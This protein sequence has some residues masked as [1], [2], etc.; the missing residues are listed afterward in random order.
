MRL[1]KSRIHVIRQLRLMIFQDLRDAIRNRCSTP[2]HFRPHGGLR[3][4]VANANKRKR[5]KTH[6]FNNHLNHHNS[7][8]AILCKFITSNSMK[9][10]IFVFVILIGNFLHTGKRL[11]LFLTDESGQFVVTGIM[12]NRLCLA[13]SGFAHAIAKREQP[14]LIRHARPSRADQ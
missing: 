8:Y 3:R 5:G 6:L 11:A 2:P 1:A 4:P 13:I 7:L 10:C 12:F 14:N 9:N